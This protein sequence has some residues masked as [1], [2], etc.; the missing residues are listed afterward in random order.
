MAYPTLADLKNTINGM[1]TVTG[2]AIDAGEKMRGSLIASVGGMKQLT[3]ETMLLNRGLSTQIG[4][5]EKLIE[6]YV[7]LAAKA[8]VFESRNKDLNKTFG[9]TSKSAALVSETIHKLAKE[10]GFAGVQAIGYATSIKKLLPTFQQQ[11]KENDKTYKS[12]QRIQHVLTIR[13]P[14]IIR[15]QISWQ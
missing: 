15:P 14:T 11:G 4:F 7:G 13:I 2:G 10:H 6:T 9:I 12:M 3:D 1:V 8:M 5:N